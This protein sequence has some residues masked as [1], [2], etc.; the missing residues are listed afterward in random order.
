VERENYENLHLNEKKLL[1]WI[2]KKLDRRVWSAFIWL[3]I[4]TSGKCL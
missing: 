2:L 4:G 1:K 3:R